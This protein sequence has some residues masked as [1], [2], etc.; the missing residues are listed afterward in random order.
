MLTSRS[1]NDKLQRLTNENNIYIKSIDELRLHSSLLKDDV[2]YFINSL[3]QNENAD[4]I[5][6]VIEE[7]RDC[8]LIL[9]NIIKFLKNIDEIRSLRIQLARLNR[10]QDITVRQRQGRQVQVP[11]AIPLDLPPA[12]PS[13]T[14]HPPQNQPQQV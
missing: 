1:I 11:T 13:N 10:R 2:F 6:S 12:P 5:A 9:E 8:M 7:S 14:A 3:I 4:E